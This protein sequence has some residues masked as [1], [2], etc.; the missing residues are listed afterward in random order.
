M[1]VLPLCVD[2]NGN[3]CCNASILEKKWVALSWAIGVRVARGAESS[4]F[5]DLEFIDNLSHKRLKTPLPCAL[6]VA[7]PAADPTARGTEVGCPGII[8]ATRS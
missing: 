7:A 1:L 6:E 3:P 4:D 2:A 8:R 5:D